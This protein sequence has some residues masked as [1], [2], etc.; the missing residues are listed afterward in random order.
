VKVV[1][2]PTRVVEPSVDVEGLY[3]D[4]ATNSWDINHDVSKL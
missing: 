3:G 1:A 4:C 2:M